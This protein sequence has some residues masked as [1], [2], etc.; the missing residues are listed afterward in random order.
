MELYA[1]PAAVMEPDLQL[2]EPDLE[3]QSAPEAPRASWKQLS[4]TL[5][6]RRAVTPRLERP[7]RLLS[8]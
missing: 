8:P 1:S 4:L 6:A 5:Q 2:R 3:L 7:L